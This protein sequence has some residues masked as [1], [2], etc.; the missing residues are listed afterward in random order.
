MITFSPEFI[1]RNEAI[2]DLYKEIYNIILYSK[3]KNK[4]LLYRKS[5]LNPLDP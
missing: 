3:N 2:N 4:I 1:F 5:T